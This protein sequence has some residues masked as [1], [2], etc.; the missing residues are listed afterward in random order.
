M[1]T[2]RAGTRWKTPL[3][4]AALIAALALL[5]GYSRELELFLRFI[6]LIAVN[7][8]MPGYHG[9]FT[10]DV[11]AIAL[12]FVVVWPVAVV[13]ALPLIRGF[14]TRRLRWDHYLA[15]AIVLASPFLGYSISQ[16]RDQARF[17]VWAPLHLDVL[18]RNPEKDGILTAWDGWGIAGMENDSYLV[19]NVADGLTSVDEANAWRTRLGLS[20]E[21]VW[22]ERVWRKL[23]V[24][25]TY[26]CVFDDHKRG[27]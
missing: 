9:D 6:A 23:Y 12:L 14:K 8:L 17:L 16:V 26:E 15:A 24:V 11:V 5:L 27:S 20:C 25:T 1:T 7:T 13:S 4:P 18:N 21:I 2:Q 3:L 22:S 19:R 10:V